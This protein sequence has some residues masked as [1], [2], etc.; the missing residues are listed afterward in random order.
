MN[1][2]LLTVRFAVVRKLDIVARNGHEAAHAPFKDKCGG[3]H[4]TVPGP[5]RASVAT[6]RPR[7]TIITTSRG[8]LV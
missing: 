8:G 6:L 4:L 3:D 1:D 7:H 5:P 2:K